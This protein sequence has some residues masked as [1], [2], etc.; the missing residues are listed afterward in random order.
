M[1]RILKNYRRKRREPNAT[2]L[3]NDGQADG[4]KIRPYPRPLGSTTLLR[5]SPPYDLTNI[6]LPSPLGEGPGVRLPTATRPLGSTT[7]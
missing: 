1:E 6:P 5:P 4:H 7:L 3:G 2:E